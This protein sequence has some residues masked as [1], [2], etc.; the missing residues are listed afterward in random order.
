MTV[1]TFT[2]YE[3]SFVHST[4]LNSLEIV[5]HGFIG[6]KNGVIKFF[7]K[8]ASCPISRS[9]II[10]KY[11][12]DH[13]TTW[14]ECTAKN[15]FFFPGFFDTHIHASQFPNSGIFGDSTLLEWLNKYTFPLESKFSVIDHAAEV[16]NKVID[17]TL[18]N[19]TTTAS[20]FTTVHV[21]ATNLLADIALK[22]KQRA[23]IGRTCMFVGCPD[24]Y[25]DI[26]ED[27]ARQSDL[28]VIEY[29][30][31]IDPKR[32]MVTPIL[33]PRFA[34]SC[35][36]EILNWHGDIVVEHD[37]PCQTHI[38]ENESEIEQV[39]EMFPSSKS[40][41]DVYEKAG[42][43]TEKTI[44]AH[45]VHLSDA[46]KE[47]LNIRRSGV[48]HCP[49]SNAS[50]SSGL[51]PVRSLLDKGIK[52]GLGTDVSGGYSPSILEVARQAL[53]T[54]RQ[55]TFLT[56]DPHNNLSVAEVLYLATLGG[57]QVC[58]LDQR[59]GNFEVGK[60]W[61]AQL[62]DLDTKGSP[63]YVFDFALPQDPL[64]RLDLLIQKWL[65]TG[66][67]R[68]TVKVWVGGALIVDKAAEEKIN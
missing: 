18:S 41:T 52:V 36:E 58:N 16:Y 31:S 48:S 35:S 38:S 4:E 6:V 5:S 17:V 7:E 13:N 29:V 32:E 68:N 11:S 50:I 24:Y 59:L 2:V 3:G 30:K 42:L 55:L 19:G 33:T 1:D 34:L 39:K 21:E 66:D 14:F 15:S 10:G 12:L 22:K 45:A 20:Y 25:R 8:E 65:F 64:V 54:S 56:K 43:L 67:D 44:L 60:Q 46:E 37:L 63:V 61:D 53:T 62:I 40:Y 51:A 27:D 9:D 47:L 57:A 49:I 28:K 26:D 23:F